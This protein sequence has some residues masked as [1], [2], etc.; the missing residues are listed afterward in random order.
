MKVQHGVA[1]LV[2]HVSNIFTGKRHRVPRLYA[3][4]ALSQ[5]LP[6]SFAQNL[7][8][9]ALIRLPATSVKDVEIRAGASAVVLVV[10][11]G[12]VAMAPA[13]AGTASLMPL[14]ILARLL[15]LTPLYLA[16]SWGAGDALPD[17]RKTV[18]PGVAALMLGFAA[19]QAYLIQQQH[20]YHE[21]GLALFSHPALSSLGCDALISAVSFV[22]WTSSLQIETGKPGKSKKLQ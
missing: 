5:I 12:S 20:T 19:W 1:A 14:I 2:S 22:A 3:F 21:I 7:F 15:L 16:R 8:Y 10:Y 6:I 11:C 4:F 18:L 9:L 17:P 13:T